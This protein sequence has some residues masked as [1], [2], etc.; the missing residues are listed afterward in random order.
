M[1]CVVHIY[2]RF[3][4]VSTLQIWSIWLKFRTCW[5][6]LNSNASCDWLKWCYKPNFEESEE[7]YNF[8]CLSKGNGR[9]EPIDI[10]RFVTHNGGGD[11][12]KIL[13]YYDYQEMLPWLHISPLNPGWQPGVSQIPLV[14]LH[15]VTA[16]W[17]DSRHRLPNSPLSHP[18]SQSIRKKITVRHPL[19]KYH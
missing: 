18:G 9:T 14:E 5:P 13:A 2:Q 16:Q 12:Y 7:N 8:N 15:P 11:N 6:I 19:I 17:Q 4:N 3:N 1:K 10:S